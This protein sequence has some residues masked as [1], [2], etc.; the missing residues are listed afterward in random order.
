MERIIVSEQFRLSKTNCSFEA[1]FNEKIDLR[2]VYKVMEAAVKALNYE[3]PYT[4]L[5]LQDL[6][7]SCETD[8]IDYQ[9]TL[10]SEAFAFYVPAMIEAVAKAFPEV[11]FE[12]HANYD[13]QRCLYIDDF[14][15][16]FSDHH[17]IITEEFDSDDY[18]YFCPECGSWIAPSW[19]DFGGEAVVCDGCDESFDV[20]RLKYVPPFVEV[21]EF[22]IY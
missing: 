8:I 18:G 7:D 9:S 15:A 4:T 20:S 13:D 12:V 22:E 5:W 21:H 16:S 10:A 17:L 19:E 6:S 3:D 14:K 1:E 11:A 2:E